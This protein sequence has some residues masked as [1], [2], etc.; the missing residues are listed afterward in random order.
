M[1]REF[2]QIR[3]SIWQDADF[4]ALTAEQQLVFLMLS[5]QPT[6]NLAGV[7][8]FLPG[9]LARLSDGLSAAKVRRIVGELEAREFVFLDE[10]TEELL[11]RSMIRTAGAWRIPNSA[12]AIALNVQQVMSRKLRSVLLTELR[13]AVAEAEGAGQW[14][15]A[16]GVLATCA[17]SLVSAGINPWVKGYA[18]PSPNPLPGEGEGEGDGTRGEGEREGARIGHLDSFPEW[19]YHWLRKKARGDAEKAYPAALKEA[20]LK[21]LCEGADRYFAWVARNSIEDRYIIGPGAWL[22]Q[23]RWED[24]LVDRAPSAPRSKT[25]TRLDGAQQLIAQYE[26]QEG[27]VIPWTGPRLLDS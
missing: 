14:E 25:T 7:L 10:E 9:R 21:A 19:W 12:Q 11:V 16:R 18:N 2:A 17:A 4:T 27:K 15:K 8:D 23:K 20:G 3:L 1:A 6:I 22:R 13:R 5:S 24:E 26:A